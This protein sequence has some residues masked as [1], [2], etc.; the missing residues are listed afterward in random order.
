MRRIAAALGG[1]VVS[2]RVLAGGFSHQTCLI[3]LGDRKVVVRF[4]GGDPVLE[5]RVMAAARRVVPVPEVLLV[6]P[7]AM[8]IEYVPG[9]VLSRVLEDGGLGTGDTGALGQ[10]TGRVV[11]SIAGVSFE[12]PGFFGPDPAA[13]P[14]AGG[15][16]IV[17]RAEVPWSRQ[18]E[19]AVV[20]CMGKVPRGRLD[21]R[22][23]V[24]WTR[25]CAEHAPVL[26]GI[27]GH[28]RLVHADINP[29]NILVSRTGTG[30]QVDSVL[31]WEFSYSGCPYG[32]AAN[33]ERFGDE[34]PDGFLEGFRE[35][36]VAGQPTDLPLVPDWELVGRVLDMFA[37][38]DLVTRPEGHVT[39]DQAAER[40]R[41]LVR[42]GLPC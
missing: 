34:Y 30:W 39:A 3:D 15:G 42:H 12:R 16:G 21:V 31:D 36:F 17:V 18:L 2:S 26:E 14:E 32:D 25:M 37:L 1:D 22:T 33:M 28:A 24:A 19:A 7:E 38:S 9:T 23:R 41:R 40:I 13:G 20:E 8:V 6:L 4:G 27:D 35:G 11:A 29:K 10:E 5:A